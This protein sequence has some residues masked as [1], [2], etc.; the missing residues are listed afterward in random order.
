MM[1]DA[2]STDVDIEDKQTRIEVLGRLVSNQNQAHFERMIRGMLWS[3]VVDITDWTFEAVRALV[4]V[5]SEENLIITFKRGNRYFMP[6]HYP[7]GPLLESFA[8][9]IMTGQF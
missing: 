8:R 4:I 3:G 6:I 7:Q 2:W 1:P 9:A 5:C